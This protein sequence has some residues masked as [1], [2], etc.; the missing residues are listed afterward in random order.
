MKTILL[1]T[2]VGPPIGILLF[3]LS[4][5]I[6]V[7]IFKNGSSSLTFG[8]GLSLFPVFFVLGYFVAIIPAFI[9]GVIA[10]FLRFENPWI[11][12]GTLVILSTT[13][14][15]IYFFYNRNYDF[16]FP[17]AVGIVT[18]IILGYIVFLKR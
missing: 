12:Y 6:G 17:S 10:T 16:L 15:L 14:C 2:F 8:Q 4:S 18:T 9:T 3:F 13:I 11:N 1:F 7:L 5:L